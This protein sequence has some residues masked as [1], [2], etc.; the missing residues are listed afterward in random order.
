MAVLPIA[1]VGHPELRIIAKEVTREEL[2]SAEVQKFIDDLVETM[3][4]ANGAGLA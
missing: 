3:R 4:H 1:T 2:A